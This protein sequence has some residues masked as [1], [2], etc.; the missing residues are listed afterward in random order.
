MN[1]TQI[2]LLIIAVVIFGY[3]F[4][5]ILSVQ[6]PQDALCGISVTCGQ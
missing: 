1:R 4:N 2:G 3:I 6:T 5:V